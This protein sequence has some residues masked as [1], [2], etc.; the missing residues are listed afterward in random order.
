MTRPTALSHESRIEIVAA[1]LERSRRSIAELAAATGLHENTVRE[2]VQRLID[3]GYVVTAREHRA[4]RG[5]PRVLYSA[6][7]GDEAQSD[8]LRARVR[9]AAERGDLLRRI[10]PECASALDAEAVHQLDAVVEDLVDAGFDPAV[11]EQHLTID[12]TPC[13]HDGADPARRAVRCR[14]H[15]A[16]LQ[17]VLAAAGGPLV[18]D[19]L[20]SSCD[21]SQCVIQLLRADADRGKATR[22]DVARA[23]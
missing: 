7:D 1:L 13:A 9:A 15:L 22:A 23:A 19:G 12:L 16:L 6:A 18:V 21:P 4:R 3:D 14:V 2:H 20:R 11:D 10:Y 5:R 8:V 17:G